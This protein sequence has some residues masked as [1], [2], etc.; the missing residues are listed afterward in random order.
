VCEFSSSGIPGDVVFVFVFFFEHAS[1]LI[2]CVLCISY[3]RPFLPFY[4]PT[5]VTRSGGPVSYP[6][7]HPRPSFAEACFL[8]LCCPATNNPGTAFVSPPTRRF[9]TARA[10]SLRLQST[11]VFGDQILCG[12]ILVGEILGVVAAESQQSA[13]PRHG[14]QQS[15]VDVL[16]YFLGTWFTS[17]PQFRPITSIDN[18]PFERNTHNLCIQSTIPA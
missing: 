13:Q 15:N 8:H 16:D 12:Q 18:Y 3:L 4:L 14:E 5:A 17:K 6:L 11:F 9:R 2:C 1:Y 7:F 10:L